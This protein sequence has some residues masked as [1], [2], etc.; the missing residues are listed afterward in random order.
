MLGS[1]SA[2]V[3]HPPRSGLAS[4]STVNPRGSSPWQPD[5]EGLSKNVGRSFHSPAKLVLAFLGFRP[6]PGGW[7]CL[8]L[9]RQ[10]VAPPKDK[11]ATVG[12]APAVGGFQQLL[13]PA[14]LDGRWPQI[15]CVCKGWQGGC[16]GM[17]SFL[18]AG[19]PVSSV[20]HGKYSLGAHPFFSPLPST[21]ADPALLPGSL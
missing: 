9:L 21:G 2:G 20:W 5:L 19:G 4:W 12:T 3:Q 17:H 10:G 13:R 6:F 14:L 1:C 7:R 18:I 15:H 11:Q 8:V 16:T